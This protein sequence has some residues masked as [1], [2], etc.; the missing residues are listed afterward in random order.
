MKC[1]VRNSRTGPYSALR[2]RHS[3]LKSRSHV[4][5]HH[6]PSPSQGE[7]HILLHLESINWHSW[8]DLHPLEIL[9]EGQTA[10]L[11]RAQEQKT[12]VAI[13][14]T[15]FTSRSEEIRISLPRLLRMVDSYQKLSDP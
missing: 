11:L 9:L 14:L 5:S 4:D 12:N 8:G 15:R 10:R 13:E 6:E 2:T 1:G 3:T 7:M